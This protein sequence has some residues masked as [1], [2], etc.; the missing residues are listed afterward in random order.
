MVQ[1]SQEQ[2][3]M[4]LFPYVREI[5][6]L[7]KLHKN[8]ASGRKKRR[9]NSY[10]GEISPAVPNLLEPDFHADKPNK[11]WVTDITEF[12]IPA[13]S[14]SKKGCTPDNA[15]CEGFFGTPKT[16]MFYG[17]SWEGVS[18]EEFIQ[19]LDNF[20][21]WYNEKRIKI[22]LG[23]MSPIDYRRSLSLVA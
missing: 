6:L 16:E 7:R 14:M 11:K 13:G 19:E 2:K 18:I 15:A 12:D 23:G 5:P 17:I 22:R 20:I 8:M 21:R 4:R 3:R 9:Y 1:F 10:M